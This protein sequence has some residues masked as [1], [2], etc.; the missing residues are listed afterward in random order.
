ML[1]SDLIQFDPIESV[2]QLRDSE[3]RD[4]ALG[5]IRSYVISKDMGQRLVDVLFPNLAIDGNPDAKGVLVVGNYGSGKSHLMSVVSAIAEDAEALES[6]ENTQVRKAAEC[7]AGRYK[8]I[9]MEIGSTTMA[10]REILTGSLTKHLAGMGVDYVFP[11][12]HEVSE[13]KTS[14]QDMMAAFHAKYPDHGLLLVVDELL[15]YLRSRKDQA[16]V[17]DLGFLREIGEVC[18][19]LRFSFMA[20]VQ[21]AIFDSG[22]FQFAADSLGRVK[23]R[24]QQVHIATSDVKFVVANR[25]LKKSAD[26]KKKIRSY[27]EGFSKFFG[28]WN[29]R[30]DDL[31]DLFPVHPGIH[32]DL[33]E[34][35]DRREA[36]R[37]AGALPHHFGHGQ[38]RGARGSAGRA[39]FRRLLGPPC[40]QPGLP[41]HP[42]RQGGDGMHLGAGG[43]G[44]E[45]LPEEAIQADGPAHHPWPVRAPA[46]D[47]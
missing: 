9:R 35:S 44:V 15:D 41:R 4:K 22:R 20:G 40:G 18:K 19:G 13:N 42:R 46:H 8:V 3:K 43:Q 32:R 6:V 45:R 24:F 34:G 23:D 5:L 31:V 10:L 47:Q 11:E 25:L 36:R 21:E 29:E 17:L 27:L 16:L 38:G 39:G 33:P 7:F 1:Y 2:V 14:L 37:P 12:S 30:M 28:D 26:Q